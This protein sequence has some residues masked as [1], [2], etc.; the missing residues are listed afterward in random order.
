M[1]RRLN[2]NWFVMS[3]AAGVALTFAARATRPDESAQARR[4]LDATG[5]QGGLIVHVGC[6][7]GKLT[8]AL[9]ANDRYL[10]HG[11]DGDAG[12]V[13]KAREH[14]RGLG[15]YGKASVARL[16]GRRLPYADNLVNLLVAEGLGE[17]PMEEVLRVLAPNGVAY[18][19]NGRE[20]AKA[21][22]PRP[23]EIDEWT[24]YL[25][26]PDNNAV[27]EDTVV[28]PPRHMQWTQEPRS[29][30][31]HDTIGGFRAVVSA[32]GR[33]F[34]IEDAGP[35]EL[36]YWPGEWYVKAR[37]AFNGKLLWKRPIR[38]WEP[39]SRPH[40]TGPVQQPRRLVAV[41]DRVYVTLGLDAPVTALDA[42]T[43]RT[44]KTYRGTE[45]TQEILFEDGVLFMVV[46]DPTFP[47]GLEYLRQRS[48][49]YGHD[50]KKDPSLVEGPEC[51][52][53]AMDARSAQ[54]L[55]RKSGAYTRGYVALSLA[56]RG[57]HAVFQNASH[58]VCLEKATGKELWRAPRTTSIT[59]PGTPPA[60][61][62]G[63]K[64]IYSADG[65][66]LKA[67]S[68]KD[69]KE[70]WSTKSKE[71]HP[72][73]G[74]NVFLIQDSVWLDH[75]GGRDPRTGE[76]EKPL[77][78]P[79]KDTMSHHRC[80]RDKATWKYL[81]LGANGVEFLPL[82]TQE[83]ISHNFV[84]GTCQYGI[85]PCNGLLYVTPDNCECNRSAKLDSYLALAAASK[86][87]PAKAAPARL[88]RG[89]AYG[90]APRSRP[91]ASAA[92]DWPVFRHDAARSGT[93][94]SLVPAD[95]KPAWSARIGGRLSQ[96]VVADG[97]A[98]VAAVEEHTVYALEARDGKVLWSYTAGGRVDSPPAVYR[99]MV[100][101]GSADG[102]VHCLRA[103]D[104]ELA[105]RFRA[106]PEERLVGAWEQLESA[107]PV[108]GSVL[109]V[110]DTLYLAAGRSTF[111][112]GGIY[113]CALDVLTGEKRR[114]YRFSGPWDEQRR[115]QIVRKTARKDIEGGLGD[116]LS[117]DGKLL[118]LRNNAFDLE[119]RPVQSV[120]K[121]HMFASAGFLDDSWNHRTTWLVGT[122]LPYGRTPQ[123][124]PPDGR[125]NLAEGEILAFDG[126]E[127]FGTRAYPMGRHSV[128]DPRESGYVLFAG[129]I[130]YKPPAPRPAGEGPAKPGRKG[131]RRAGKAGSGKAKRSGRAAKPSFRYV[132]KWLVHV[133]AAARGM[134]RT[135]DTLFIAG[136][137][138]VYDPRDPSGAIRG[139]KG[140]VL[141]AISPSDGRTLA[142]Y[143]L[144]SPPVFDGLIAAGGRLYLA[145]KDG[146]IVCMAGRK[147]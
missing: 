77:G 146:R 143:K 24:H 140:G 107:W 147:P 84:R 10:V 142:E 65:K 49:R 57:A 66:A 132:G 39:V 125:N 53:V 30:R 94:Q 73:S 1:S 123:H 27:A 116:I 105:W 127:L 111:L 97:K 119:C 7:E 32:G 141:L 133:Q 134:V 115:H 51:R 20:W 72:V 100:L 106:A 88:Q 96:P 137:P 4:I 61:V 11:L 85:V 62:I 26:G 126:K 122:T 36:P 14:I 113:L 6:G 128:F 87:P 101:F 9:R 23:Q 90:G 91:R 78:R 5:V 79:R 69:G 38:N 16:R 144:D 103:S 48:K 58:L 95:L 131:G 93:T 86:P 136:T 59:K 68:L 25:H 67:F 135:A 3:A 129:A 63:R 74:P 75:T 35:I 13:A 83:D 52:I 42:A 54:G 112:D 12:K 71:G 120:E 55:W 76:L 118:Y 8:A 110:N 15:L 18:V 19:R 130:D 33:I 40:R 81:L 28:G 104:G 145:T 47:T 64:A 70:L 17:V 121:P 60:V 44:L 22:K 89:P 43:G 99:G 124:Y 21:T 80:Y 117:C 98:F 46:G 31:H 50:L 109:I 41:G 114:E 37:D 92:A 82:G 139:R 29:D 138:N 34:S 2:A 45:S 102:W 56:V 108:H